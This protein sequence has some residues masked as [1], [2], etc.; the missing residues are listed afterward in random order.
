MKLKI[1]IAF[2][3]KY[4]NKHYKVGDIINVDADRAK[5]LLDDSRHLVSKAEIIREPIK[6]DEPPK[7]R[8]SKK[9]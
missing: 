4:T 5:E 9:K 8:G 1:E 3:D 2:R 6:V 7:R